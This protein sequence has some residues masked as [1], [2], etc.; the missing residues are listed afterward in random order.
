MDTKTIRQ[1]F[2]TYFKKKGHHELPSSSLIPENDPTLLFANAGMNQFKDIFTGKKKASWPRAITIQKC[3]RA[4]GKHNDLENVGFTSRHHTFFEMLGNFSFGDY[5]KK[6]AIEM[7]YEFLTSEL[8]IP[9]DRLYFTVHLSDQEAYDLWLKDIKVP[10]ERIFKKDADNFWEMGEFGPC[11]PCSEIFYDHGEAYATKGFSVPEGGDILDDESRYVEI[12]NLVF[13]QYERTPEGLLKLPNPSV[14]TGGGLERLACVLQN[15]YWNYDTDCF[16]PIINTIEALSGLKYAEPQKAHMRVIAD[17]MRSATMLISDGV[18]PSHE[19]RG[20][21]LRRI[22]RRAVRHVRQLQE[23]SG[24]LNLTA[25]VPS[26][27]STLGET[28]PDNAKNRPLVEKYLA[29]EEKKFLE[30]L[31][32]GLKYLENILQDPS[33]IASKKSIVDGAHIFKLY[34]TF[35]FPPDLT[36]VILKEKNLRADIEGLQRCMEKQKALSRKSWKG[37]SG[38]ESDTASQK[39]ASQYPP[40]EFV[41]Y[42]HF[43]YDSQ[44]LGLFTLPQEAVATKTQE[45]EKEKE[46]EKE[47]RESSKPKAPTALL[48]FQKTPFYGE[49]GGQTGDSGFVGLSQDRPLGKILDTQKKENVFLHYYEGPLEDLK[50]GNTYHLALQKRQR[51]LSAGHHSATHLLNKALSEVLG[52]HVKQAGSLVSPSRLRFDFTHPKALTPKEMQ[53]IEDLVNQQIQRALPVTYEVLEKNEALKKGAQALFGEKY[54]QKVRVIQMGDFSIE[55]CGGTHVKNTKD[56]LSF[57]LLSD[58]S[59]SAGVR[60]VEALAGNAVI[61]HHIHRSK[62]L[63]KFETALGQK[64]QDGLALLKQLQAK[65]K[66]LEKEKKELQNTIT[67]LEAEAL[68]HSSTILAGQVRFLCAKAPDNANLKVLSDNFLKKYP[69]KALAIFYSRSSKG[70]NIIIRRAK[71]LEAIDCRDILSSSLNLLGG[72]GGGRPDLAQGLVNGHHN[73]KP[74][75]DHATKLINERL[76]E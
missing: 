58:S 23:K 20:H 19:G 75:L 2:L 16:S 1:K 21:V 5:F 71:T 7:A 13:M 49:S 36:E 24:Q 39:F 10:A 4:G 34:D 31:D 22:I 32:Q 38:L 54:G 35:G 29:I 65:L 56:L 15:V 25:L 18:I 61:E 76:C 60:R 55:F 59:L 3:V 53:N 72:K 57:S 64:E 52:N 44:L 9:K 70:Q 37:S 51:H 26:V 17:H 30:T 63:K 8:K 50:V 43:E 68:F 67:A 33:F 45:R 69:E 11:G 73:I 6:G 74:V 12:W 47:E 27:L 46:E 48:V 28:Y 66:G 14:D 42:E 40:T 41:G 62:L